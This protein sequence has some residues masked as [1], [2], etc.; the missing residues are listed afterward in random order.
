MVLFV[1]LQVVA[2]KT[3]VQQCCEP[4]LQSS[5]GQRGMQI[6]LTSVAVHWC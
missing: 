4:V 3:K 1:P 2:L 5:T 6:T